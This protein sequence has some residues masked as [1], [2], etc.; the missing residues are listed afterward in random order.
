MSRWRLWLAIAWGILIVVY[1]LKKCPATLQA[2]W[3]HDDLMNCY[4]ALEASYRS[5]FTDIFAFWQ[6]T[7]FYR[8]LGQMFYKLL[9]DQYGLSQLPYR[10]AVSS[11]LVTNAYLLGIL[12][13]RL[14]GN[15]IFGL[16]V[17]AVCAYHPYWA[18]L[19]LNTGTIFEILAFTFVFLGLLLHVELRTKAWG[20]LPVFACFVLAVN[21]KES[22][23]LLPPFVVLYELIWWRR[24]PWRTALLLGAGAVA[25]IF[26]RVYGPG[27][28]STI[29]MYEPAY[30]WQ[31]YLARFQSYF[32]HLILWKSAPAW[33]CILL[34][35]LPALTRSKEGV[36]ASL[37]FP[38]GILPLAFVPERGLEA[39]YVASAALALGVGALVIKLPKERLQLAG[40]ILVA[41]GLVKIFPPLK[42]RGGWETEQT[43]I[44]A[45]H[46]QLKQ[47]A[48]QMPSNVQIRFE[49]EP[50][51]P[52][53]PWASV[54]ATRLLYRD[55]TIEVAGENNPHTKDNPRSNDFAVFTWEDG[56]M[57]RLK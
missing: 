4:R 28:V 33:T 44:R 32:G 15:W 26:G 39:V 40:L 51:P 27:G 5:I 47:L 41:A 3:S 22:G 46:E 48:P 12:G 53:S 45:F 24:I 18:H 35:A 7:P 31:S 8:P 14:S 25:F 34:C 16:A 57:R 55:L 38:L 17:A 37:V 54:F 6:P 2:D 1:F 10:I 9:F 13:W 43:D 36:F 21:A 23:I 56:Q 29:G 19:Y 50:F 30:N 49:K 42:D 52:D 11:L 20:P